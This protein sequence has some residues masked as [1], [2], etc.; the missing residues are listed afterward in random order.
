MELSEQI[1]SAPLIVQDGRPL[2]VIA[3]LQLLV[4]PEELVTVTVYVFAELTVMHCV[5]APVLHK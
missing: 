3:L 1:R 4:Q 2:M 5:V